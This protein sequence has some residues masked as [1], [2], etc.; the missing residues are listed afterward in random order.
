ME[1]QKLKVA[2]NH[3]AAEWW[4]KGPVCLVICTWADIYYPIYCI[5]LSQ[6]A[7]VNL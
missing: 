6:A 3:M 7:H 4:A 2:P 5:P 1:I